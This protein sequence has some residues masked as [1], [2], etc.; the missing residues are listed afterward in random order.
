M[1]CKELPNEDAPHWEN[2]LWGITGARAT[3][4][5]QLVYLIH[6]QAFLNSK[7]VYENDKGQE[8]YEFDF[9][10]LETLIEH[11]NQFYYRTDEK[12]IVLSDE[13]K[14][15][16]MTNPNLDFVINFCFSY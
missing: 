3:T 4:A 14:N 12:K 13:L 7:F 1:L 6:L 8:E 2:S 15:E 9:E 5:A 10:E 16:L 11:E